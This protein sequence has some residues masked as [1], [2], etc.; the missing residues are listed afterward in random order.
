MRSR[1]ALHLR[2][3]ASAAAAFLVALAAPFGGTARSAEA[4]PLDASAFA[5]IVPVGLA[6]GCGD[7]SGTPAC[8]WMDPTFKKPL[9]ILIGKLKSAELA[10]ETLKSQQTAKSEKQGDV[11]DVVV[12]SEIT[13]VGNWGQEA[14]EVLQGYNIFKLNAAGTGYEYNVTRTFVINFSRDCYAVTIQTSDS[15]S[16]PHTAGSGPLPD[17]TVQALFEAGT[18]GDVRA[19]APA[20]DKKL[21]DIPCGSIKI[22]PVV[23]KRQ[24]PESEQVDKRLEFSGNF[25][26]ANVEAPAPWW[27]PPPQ[28]PVGYVPNFS[29]WS[30]AARMAQAQWYE[31]EAL[32]T[33]HHRGL[34]E[35][36]KAQNQRIKAYAH[37]VRW[38]MKRGDVYDQ[39][40]YD[41]FLKENPKPVYPLIGLDAKA[42]Y[43]ANF[44]DPPK[45]L[46]FIY[47]KSPEEIW[48]EEHWNALMA[49]LK[50][51]VVVVPLGVIDFYLTKGF[52]VSLYYSY[53]AYE[54]NPGSPAFLMPFAMNVTL[55]TPAGPPL[56]AAWALYHEI[57]EFQE[58]SF[59]EHLGNI[60]STLTAGYQSYRMVTGKTRP[61][62]GSIPIPEKGINEGFINPAL[63]DELGGRTF[64]VVERVDGA[65]QY[66]KVR[67]GV[68]GRLDGEKNEAGQL[69]ENGRPNPKAPY[70]I[71]EAKFRVVDSP[72]GPRYFTV[73]SD[74][75]L[76]DP[77][78]FLGEPGYH[79]WKH[80]TELNGGSLPTGET[81]Y[82]T[83]FQGMEY[84]A[85]LAEIETMLRDPK[86]P[87]AQANARFLAWMKEIT[88]A[89]YRPYMVH[90]VKDKDPALPTQPPARWDAWGHY[91][92]V[93]SKCTGKL[94]M[95]RFGVNKEQKVE[96]GFVLSEERV[97]GYAPSA[98][99]RA[100]YG[101]LQTMI[102]QGLPWWLYTNVHVANFL[103]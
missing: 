44:V 84:E 68:V 85:E 23:C 10:K 71:M 34:L 17:D 1:G 74:G 58:L 100:E 91:I 38:L 87:I 61:P 69:I 101:G 19:L 103:Q 82:R 2:L 36:S 18:I 24:P 25:L 27:P 41:D 47:D 78:F 65:N 99:K 96:G 9:S 52:L 98:D 72:D 12:I 81:S 59:P 45:D 89:E 11:S 53:R 13:G 33:A 32:L 21:K 62:T 6:G 31:V 14:S 8:M 26:Q 37:W 5:D 48:Q 86:V 94:E 64:Q 39:A 22:M 93:K 63:K 79:A 77:V 95:I 102:K 66:H 60:V 4:P 92:A 20:F 51:S 40:A 83:V 67:F 42:Y 30:I 15:V 97:I 50:D 29:A 7:L 70:D 3:D 57:S 28:V 55:L 54:E 76:K 73:N 46:R 90:M 88:T 43:E 56:L 80:L 35:V 75:T 16:V 49:N